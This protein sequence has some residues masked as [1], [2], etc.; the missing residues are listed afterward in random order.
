MGTKVGMK[1]D[2]FVHDF[3]IYLSLCQHNKCNFV[4]VHAPI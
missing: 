2:E 4:H 1:V 3:S